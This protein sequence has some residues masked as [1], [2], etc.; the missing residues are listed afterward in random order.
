MVV[1]HN[2]DDSHGIEYVKSHLKET[3]TSLLLM[4]EIRLT[5]WGW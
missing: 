4:A 1:K 3:Q 5:S 2:G